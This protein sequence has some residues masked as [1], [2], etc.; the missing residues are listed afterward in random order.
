[1]RYFLMNQYLDIPT[2]R[3]YSSLGSLIVYVFVFFFTLKVIEN[4]KTLEHFIVS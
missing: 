2:G 3:W 1:M 4:I